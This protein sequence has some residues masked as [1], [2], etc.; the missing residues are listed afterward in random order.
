MVNIARALADVQQQS[1]ECAL[2][3][4]YEGNNVCAW[5]GFKHLNYLVEHAVL[6]HLKQHGLSS[7][8]IYEEYGLG[9]DVVDI[10]TRILNSVHLDDEVTAT[11][12]PKAGN[13]GE[14]TFRVVLSTD[15]KTKDVTST[16]R[17]VLRRDTY[18]DA[19]DRVPEELRPFTTDEIVRPVPKGLDAFE[20][21][22]EI[23]ADNLCDAF[24]GD[25]NGVCWSTRISYPFCHYNERMAMS[26]YL[27][28]MEAGKDRFVAARGIS[29]KTLLDS[30]RW[31]PAVPHSR[32]TMLAE[33][34]MEETLYVVYTV[35]EVFKNLTYRSRFDCYVLRDGVPLR[36]ASGTIMHGY[37]QIH[38]R[39][40]WSLVQFDDRVLAALTN[41]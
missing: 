4:M 23:A 7:R 38:R 31:I 14:W 1:S 18:I 41:A 25:R 29:V 39:D 34:R 13:P 32:I 26:G 12:T 17:T 37:A 2:V 8:R 33:A 10:D 16:V 19:T 21:L 9:V 15:G 6:N 27:R 28:L 3:P 40:D 22:G 5:I 11:V 30:N 24:V 36:T 20:P 35:E